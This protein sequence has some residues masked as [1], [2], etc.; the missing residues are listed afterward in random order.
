MTS[1]IPYPSC[2]NVSLALF[3]GTVASA[4]ALPFLPLGIC[5]GA[6]IAA[7]FTAAKISESITPPT[8]L[9]SL[10]HKT[11]SCRATRELLEK[12]KRACGT[13][14]DIRLSEGECTCTKS[15]IVFINNKLPEREA[16]SS[17]VYELSRLT[18]I[19]LF[20]EHLQSYRNGDLTDD[21]LKTELDAFFR[22]SR[23]VYNQT[24]T[25]ALT[26]E[27]PWASLSMYTFTCA[28][29]LPCFKRNYS[30]SIAKIIG[31]RHV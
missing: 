27:A 10:I 23:Q 4:I 19:Q 29:V 11:Q 6:G 16:M 22:K 18:Q 25:Q 9:D 30:D 13:D 26:E 28:E 17:L 14:L 1:C 15:G 5:V 7:G 8:E 20:S 21:Q 31:P 2:F 12:A 24:I 3:T